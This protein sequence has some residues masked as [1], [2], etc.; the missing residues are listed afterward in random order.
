MCENLCAIRPAKILRHVRGYQKHAASASRLADDLIIESRRK[1][2]HYAHTRALEA[3]EQH[4]LAGAEF[5]V[6]GDD[7]ELLHVERR[8][9]LEVERPVLEDF[10]IVGC[11]IIVLGVDVADRGDD[12]FLRP[13]GHRGDDRRAV[14]KRSAVFLD[15]DVVLFRIR[16]HSGD[17]DQRGGKCQS[18]GELQ[19]VRHD[20]L[21]KSGRGPVLAND[22]PA[23]PTWQQPSNF[24][25]T[26]S[27]NGT[28]H[29]A[30]SL[31]S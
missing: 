24:W 4:H 8:Q 30:F 11:V 23:R 5:V 29:P 3:D 28:A 6:L 16:A 7:V 22:G 17:R 20:H 2:E 18:G 13:A 10:Q 26:C 21:P 12:L 9:S 1:T 15:E 27:T 19:P 14:I 25:H 31:N